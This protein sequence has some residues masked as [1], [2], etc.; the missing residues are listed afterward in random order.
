MVAIRSA[1]EIAEKWARVTPGLTPDYEAGAKN[2]NK[3][4][5]TQTL[6]AADA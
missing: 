2:P 5:E 1:S 6:A 3:D 4:W